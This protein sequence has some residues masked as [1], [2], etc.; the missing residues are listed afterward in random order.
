MRLPSGQQGLLRCLR[1]KAQLVASVGHGSCLPQTRRSG[2][3]PGKD[4][5][6]A[7]LGA[8]PSVRRLTSR[9]CRASSRES[10]SGGGGCWSGGATSLL[11]QCPPVPP[12]PPPI[13]PTSAALCRR[14]HQPPLPSHLCGSQGRCPITVLRDLL[15]KMAQPLIPDPLRGWGSPDLRPSER[16]DRSLPSTLGALPG[17]STCSR[18]PSAIAFITGPFVIMSSSP[19]ARQALG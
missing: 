5:N 11:S 18:W 7:L 10:G 16:R 12:P 13:G 6:S 19:T 14:R 3:T 4:G 1:R 9:R 17:L 2:Q 8:S 15:I